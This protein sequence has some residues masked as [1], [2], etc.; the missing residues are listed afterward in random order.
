M[1]KK[2]TSRPDI[3]PNIHHSGKE[4]TTN[5][6][7]IATPTLGSVRIEWVNA[8]YAQ[9]IPT[10]WSNAFMTANLNPYIVMYYQVADAQNMI[11]KKAV[12][13]NF[14]WLLLIEDDTMPPAD[15]FVRFNE[16]MLKDE[17]PVVS[18]LYYTKS[19]PATPLVFRGRG[20]GFYDDW[21]LGD[22]V[23]C[24]GVPTGMLLIK[25]K[26]LELM[27]ND[28][29]EYTAHNGEKTRKVFETPNRQWLD[30]E[31]GQFNA[32]VGTSDLD[33]CTRVIQGKYLEKAGYS[34]LQKKKYPFLVDT[35]IFC[36]HIDR[37]TGKIYPGSGKPN[38]KR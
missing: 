13:D 19:N 9:I 30:E 34:K 38:G 5:R 10:N 37:G 22:K 11:V 36:Q 26:L 25:V 29:P 23:W 17:L 6:I 3:H 12:E 18:G 20:T 28:S 4:Q 14:E 2:L 35:Q 1:T 33:W 16:Y 21:K 31:T 24:D 8:R 15:A 27:W 7:L 32:I